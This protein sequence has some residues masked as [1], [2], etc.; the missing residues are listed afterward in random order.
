MTLAI[1]TLEPTLEPI[2][3]LNNLFLFLSTSPWYRYH[4]QS[5]IY[6]SFDTSLEFQGN[7]KK[8]LPQNKKFQAPKEELFWFMKQIGYKYTQ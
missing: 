6:T 3:A 7:K 8:I 2:L 4:S 5:T 1:P